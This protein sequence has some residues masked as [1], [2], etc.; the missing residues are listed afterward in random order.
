[1]WDIVWV[2]AQGHRSV[3]V[4]RHFLLQTPQCPC[5]VR[6]RFS[7]DQCCR[8]RL[9]PGYRIVGSHTRW[10]LTTEPTSSYASIDFWCQRRHCNHPTRNS[11]LLFVCS[12]QKD[13]EQVPFSLRCDQYMFGVKSLLMVEKVL[14]MRKKLVAV[15]FW[16][17]MQRL[18]RLISLY[19]MWWNKCLHEFR[20]YV[21]KWNINVWH[22]NTF[23]CWTC[24]LF[25][26]NIT[27]LF[28]TC[29]LQRKL[30]GKILHWLTAF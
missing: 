12:G 24:S 14:L 5:S 26:F 19:G 2:S 13:L 7:R 21:E 16:Q 28:N 8:G 15:L 18:Q 30:L 25:L 6:K 29:E 9:K 10:E 27:M 17:P 3:S 4:S 1:M 20:W 22:L 23:A 11:L